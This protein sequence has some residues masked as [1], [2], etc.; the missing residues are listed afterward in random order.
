MDPLLN[1]LQ[2][3]DSF[4]STPSVP[5]NGTPSNDDLLSTKNIMLMV[6]ETNDAIWKKFYQTPAKKSQLDGLRK[7]LSE[8][9]SSI[10]Y[11]LIN[12]NVKD[13]ELFNC[14]SAYI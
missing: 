7:S 12:K 10:E 6:V 9:S 11:P 2:I 3:S 8:K 1:I 14:D 5:E 13:L 4:S